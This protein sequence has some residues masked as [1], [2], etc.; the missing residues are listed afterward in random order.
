MSSGKSAS[1][2]SEPRIDNRRQELLA[3]A[4]RLFA[5]HG[6]EATS[7]RDIAGEVGMLAGSMYY[8]FRSKEELVAATHGLGV[9]QIIE[10]VSKAIAGVAEPWTRLEAA[11]VAHLQSLLG[12][13]DFAAVVRQEFSRVS[14]SLRKRLIAQRDEYEALFGSVVEALPLKSRTDRRLLRLM[15]LGALNA[16]PVWYRPGGE[17]P[18]TIARSFV[19]L[20]R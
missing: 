18:A 2:R 15:L 5:R 14:P 20:L 6:F 11:C 16:T 13:S 3:A 9:R 10:A 7:M 12:G 1:A 17:A 19:T 8:H 4:A